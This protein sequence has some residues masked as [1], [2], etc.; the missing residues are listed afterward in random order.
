MTNRILLVGD[1]HAVPEELDDCRAL[2]ELVRTVCKDEK[3]NEVL[4]LGDLYNT[5]NVMRVEVLNFWKTAF[6]ALTQDKLNVWALVGNHD[7][8]GEGLLIHSMMAHQDQIKVVNGPMSLAPNVLMLPY[9]ADKEQFLKVCHKNRD[10]QTLICHQTFSGATYDNGMYAPDGIDPAD[11]PQTTVIG[12]HVHCLSDDTE[13][14]TRSGWRSKDHVKPGDE[15][16]T[17]TIDGHLEYQS[18]ERVIDRPVNEPMYNIKSVFTDLLVTEGH[19]NASVRKLGYGEGEGLVFW[20]ASEVQD[21]ERLL[22]SGHMDRS[23]SNLTDDEIRLCVW[24]AADG[25]IDKFGAVVW[26]LKKDRK[27]DR[28]QELLHRLGANYALYDMATGNKKIRLGVTEPLAKWVCS[29]FDFGKNKRL[30]DF[31]RHLDRRQFD[32]FFEEYGV[33]DGRIRGTKDSMQLITTK[34]E[35]VDI[36]QEL[37][38]LNGAACSMRPKKDKENCF[39]LNILRNR[40]EGMISKTSVNKVDYDKHRTV[41]CITVPNG[42]IVAR[43]NGKVTITGNCPQSF[44]KVTYVGSPRWRTL[45]DAN[46]DK[47]VVLYTFG[48]EGEVLETKSFDTSGHCRKIVALTDTPDKP[49]SLEMSPNTDYRIDIKGPK[50]WIEKRKVELAGVGIRIRT[51]CTEKSTPKVRESEGISV[52]FQKYLETYVGKH[53]TPSEVLSSLAKERLHV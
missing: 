36:I 22:L 32:I 44:G 53:G 2:I 17:A 40:T 31:M 6:D 47:A 43:R 19:R 50:D 24:V 7:Y 5:H 41:W 48:D 27:I 13:I 4:F 39:V 11:I 10:M 20:T 49:L 42:T 18:I 29:R 16:V 25:T 52:A 45:S 51:F 21:N 8:A 28:I 12:G 14:L 37:C 26:H 1:V 23:S 15:V 38:A 33:T 9:M 3:V 46:I 35:E 34:K 30:P